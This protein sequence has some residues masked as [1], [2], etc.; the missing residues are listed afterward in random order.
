MFVERLAV[1]LWPALSRFY[2]LGLLFGRY[3]TGIYEI[4]Q[5]LLWQRSLEGAWV[6]A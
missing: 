2:F 4:L 5:V 1:G 3:D 6:K